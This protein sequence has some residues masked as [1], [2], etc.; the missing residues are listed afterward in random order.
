MWRG[1]VRIL[2]R[3]IKLNF[4]KICPKHLPYSGI[5]QRM[6]EA[7]D[8]CQPM[9]AVNMGCALPSKWLHTHN[10]TPEFYSKSRPLIFILTSFH[11]KINSYYLDSSIEPSFTQMISTKTVH[12]VLK[13]FASFDTFWKQLISK[14]CHLWILWP[15]LFIYGHFRF[16]RSFLKVT[17]YL[18]ISKY[19]SNT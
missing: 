14:T 5:G 4:L 11:N 1:M 2:W 16:I 17:K 18:R 3:W 13:T 9:N 10:F 7:G 12:I 15:R 6:G 8:L 19:Y